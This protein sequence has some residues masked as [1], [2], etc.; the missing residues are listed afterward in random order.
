[1]YG[2]GRSGQRE[3]FP[4]PSDGQ[5]SAAGNALA[6]EQLRPAMGGAVALYALALLYNCTKQT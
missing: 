1:M 3:F 4:A 5:G 6:Y 2:K